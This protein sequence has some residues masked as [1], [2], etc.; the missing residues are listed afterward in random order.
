MES[1]TES[2]S[3]FDVCYPCFSKDFFKVVDNVLS[4]IYNSQSWTTVKTEVCVQRVLNQWRGELL[5]FRVKIYNIRECSV[6]KSFYNSC[7]SDFL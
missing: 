6:Q 4:K 3:I 1:Q 2:N 5:I 7:F